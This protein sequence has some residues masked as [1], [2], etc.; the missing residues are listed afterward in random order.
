MKTKIFFLSLIIALGAIAFSCQQKTEK[1]KYNDTQSIIPAEIAINA[2]SQDYVNERLAIYAPFELS[3]DLSQLSEN[4]V[5]IIGICYEVARIM[6]G[7]FWRQTIGGKAEFIS[8]ITNDNTRKFAKINYGPWDRLNNNKPF[9]EGVGEKPKGANFYPVDM[10][11][12]EFDAFDDPNKTSLYTLIRRDEN[13]SLISVW[14]HQAY[15]KELQQASELLKEAATLAEDPGLKKYLELRAEA[16]I[17][18]DSLTI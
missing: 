15:A 11:K 7:L 3:A 4:E 10:T 13:G 1:K 8:G 2:S 5:K 16:L 9:I 6:D 18:D 14:Y 17:T 12:D